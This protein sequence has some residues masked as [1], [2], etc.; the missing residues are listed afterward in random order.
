MVREPLV[1]MAVAGA[2]FVLYGV[3]LELENNYLKGDKENG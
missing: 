3:I 2:L 1:R